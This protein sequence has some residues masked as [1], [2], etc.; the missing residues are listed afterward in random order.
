MGTKQLVLLVT[1][2][3]WIFADAHAWP[4]R[5]SMSHEA[6]D[7]GFASSRRHGSDGLIDAPLRILSASAH[8]PRA[9]PF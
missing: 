4:V 8:L 2:P 9:M 3:L 5:H 6:K 7:S 1:I